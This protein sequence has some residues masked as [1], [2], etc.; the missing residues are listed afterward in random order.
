MGTVEDPNEGSPVH[1]KKKNMRLYHSNAKEE[2][3]DSETAS[4]VETLFFK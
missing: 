4:S 2:K 1:M 3:C